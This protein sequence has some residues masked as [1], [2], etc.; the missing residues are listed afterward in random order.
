MNIVLNNKLKTFGGDMAIGAAGLFTT[1][2]QLIVMVVIGICQGMQPIIGYNFGAG[3]ISRLQRTFWLAVTAASVVTAVGFAAAQLMPRAIAR[4]FTTDAELIAN[5]ASGLRTAMSM[6]FVVGFQ[7][8]ATTLF[9]SIGAAA[10]SI[11]LSLTRQVL[12]VIPMLL[13]L[14]PLLGLRGVW[15]CFPMS[16]LAA[17]LV[18][19]F[20]V[21][22]QLRCFSRM[23]DTAALAEESDKALE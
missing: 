7:I 20:M 14:P 21:A 4:A 11:F 10:K 18:T 16:D 17:T 15:I 6:F 5:T 19:A 13:T 9:Q 3:R 2:T 23:G 12:F 1:Y 22:W 8:I